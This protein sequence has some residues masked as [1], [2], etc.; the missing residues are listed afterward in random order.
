MATD[1]VLEALSFVTTLT[2][3]RDE[4]DRARRRTAAGS[5]KARVSLDQLSQVTGIPRSTV[6]AYL[7]GRVTPSPQVL[8]RLVVA[9]GADKRERARLGRC[10]RAGD[11]A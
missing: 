3:L 10:A 4:L 11:V 9:L 8:D 6:H 7:S 1:T 5:G 2:A